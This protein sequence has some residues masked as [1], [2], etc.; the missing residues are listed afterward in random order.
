MKAEIKNHISLKN[1]NKINFWYRDK[2]QTTK[3]NQTYH[4]INI[5]VVLHYR[6]I[7]TISYRVIDESE[8]ISQALHNLL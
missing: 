5:L 6:D 4:E 1:Q 8:I 7:D 2:I 3:I